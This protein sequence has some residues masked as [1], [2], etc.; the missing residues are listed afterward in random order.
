[1]PPEGR[2]GGLDSGPGRGARHHLVVRVEVAPTLD[3]LLDVGVVAQRLVAEV[4]PL[5][6]PPPLG[7]AVFPGAV[8]PAEEEDELV[9]LQRVLAGGAD[10][11][12]AA[13]RLGARLPGDEPGVD[14][15]HQ[16][17]GG[18]PAG[19]PPGHG[20]RGLAILALEVVE[21][22]PVVARLAVVER[23]RGA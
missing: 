10:G 4:E 17:P 22:R 14:V 8:L 13:D 16:L 23:G 18:R 11:V 21:A 15:V 20:P 19:L 6:D 2:P 12:L 3:R 9:G 1:G 7:N 5:L